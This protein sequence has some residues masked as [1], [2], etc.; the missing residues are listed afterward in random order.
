[1]LESITQPKKKNGEKEN[2]G[3]RLTPKSKGVRR[4]LRNEKDGKEG[5]KRGD[6]G[7]TQPGK[8]KE[9]F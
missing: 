3:T 8:R 9:T 2:G 1:L 7:K 4:W 6:V 5:T